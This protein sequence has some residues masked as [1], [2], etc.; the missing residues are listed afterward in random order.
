VLWKIV[1]LF[2]LALAVCSA[3]SRV[4]QMQV[5]GKCAIPLIRMKI[6]PIDPLM[7]IPLPESRNWTMPKVEVP[8]PSCDQKEAKP[9]KISLTPLPVGPPIVSLRR[10]L[11]LTGDRG[12]SR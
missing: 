6:V 3:Q 11:L 10:P 5:A 7:V 2:P 9:Q 12:L 8:A 1:V 4:V